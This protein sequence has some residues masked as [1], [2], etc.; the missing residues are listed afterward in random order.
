MTWYTRELSL[1]APPM[2]GQDVVRLQRLLRARLTGRYDEATAARVRGWQALH[3]LPV[4]G[5][6]DTATASSIGAG[7]TYGHLPEWYGTDAQERA[8]R[9]RLG[10]TDP[11]T[12][13]RFQ[14][15]VRLPP[16]GTVDE[17]TAIEIGDLL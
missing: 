17:T 13:K 2:H 14:S 1:E 5:T 12:I 7:A 16:T 3:G 8:V 9:T 15:A 11:D 10:A 6:V 4:T